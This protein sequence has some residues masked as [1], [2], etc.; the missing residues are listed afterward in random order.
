MDARS[1]VTIQAGSYSCR[2]IL[3]KLTRERGVVYTVQ[4]GMIFIEP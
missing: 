4:G 2:E 3:D 1:K